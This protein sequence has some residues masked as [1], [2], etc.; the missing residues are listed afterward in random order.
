MVKRYIYSDVYSG[1]REQPQESRDGWIHSADYDALEAEWMALSQDDGKIKRA[2]ES[3]Q[4]RIRELEAAL[5]IIASYTG[6]DSA[7][8]VAKEMARGA[9]AGSALDRGGEHG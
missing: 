4:A 5:R 8:W 7:A 6:H 2:L 3:A 9:L 1:M